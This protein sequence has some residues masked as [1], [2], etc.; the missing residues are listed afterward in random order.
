MSVMALVEA[1][2]M[3]VSPTGK[4]PKYSAFLGGTSFFHSHNFT[5]KAFM[6][7]RPVVVLFGGVL[8]LWLVFSQSMISQI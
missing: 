5:K 4:A 8:A 3:V 6:R 1:T 2:Q 7:S